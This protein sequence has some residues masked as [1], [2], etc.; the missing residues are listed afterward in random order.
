MPWC[1]NAFAAAFEV[2]GEADCSFLLSCRLPLASRDVWF[3]LFDLWSILRHCHCKV[4]SHI[5]GLI[6][7]CPCLFEILFARWGHVNS[8]VYIW[9]SHCFSCH[10]AASL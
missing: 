3:Q 6:L 10:K 7:C 9:Q 4:Q 2:P 1:W 8:R 5:S